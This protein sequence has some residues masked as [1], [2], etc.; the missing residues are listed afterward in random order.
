MSEQF[1]DS[2][3]LSNQNH[4]ITFEKPNKSENT[5]SS[6]NSCLNRAKSCFEFVEI[7]VK[8]VLFVGM[9]IFDKNVF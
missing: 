2:L 5:V 1:C 8:L 4:V 6:L 9:F 3:T 7:I